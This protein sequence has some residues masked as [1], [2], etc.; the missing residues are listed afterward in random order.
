VPSGHRPAKT[1]ATDE[2]GI[3]RTDT[4]KGLTRPADIVLGPQNMPSSEDGR[5]L[6]RDADGNPVFD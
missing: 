1:V 6:I 3:V 5:G 2:N 4:F